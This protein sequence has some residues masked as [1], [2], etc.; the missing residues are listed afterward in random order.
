M[1]KGVVTAPSHYENDLMW[2]GYIHIAGVD[3]A[4]RGPLAGPVVACAVILPQYTII[5][6]ANDSKKLS[7]KRREELAVAIKE[8]AL[9]YAFGFGTVEEIEEINILQASLLAMERAING[10]AQKPCAALIDGNQLPKNLP[11]PAFAVT[12][13]DSKSHITACASILAKVERDKLMAE[14]D[15][16][17]PMYGF[18]QHKGYGTAAHRKALE[19]FGLCPHHRKSFC[20]FVNIV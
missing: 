2:Q 7:A 14:L 8:Q 10:L 18:A 9:A 11:F 1:R 17:F 19:E 16:E 20:K 13:G 6:G 12:Q 3:E 4:G 5:E 15:L